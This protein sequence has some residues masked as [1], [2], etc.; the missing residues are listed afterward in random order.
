MAFVFDFLL[1]FKL[2]RQ[3]AL[4]DFVGFADLMRYQKTRNE[5]LVLVGHCPDCLVQ[6]PHSAGF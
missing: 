4:Q 5:R 3:E 1:L 6:Q 2:F